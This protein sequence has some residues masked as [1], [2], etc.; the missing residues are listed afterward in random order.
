MYRHRVILIALILL[1]PVTGEAQVYFAFD[2]AIYHTCYDGDT[3]MM[4]LPDTHPLF[5]EH[6]PVRLAGIDT[7][8]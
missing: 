5:G 8:K 2:R 4:S 6:I 7:P 1:W 3:C